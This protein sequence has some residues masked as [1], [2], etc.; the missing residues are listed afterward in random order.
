MYV[1][2]ISKEI[3]SLCHYHECMHCS[4][5][6]CVGFSIIRTIQLKYWM[7]FFFF[8]DIVV[9]L[10]LFLLFMFT[11]VVVVAVFDFQLLL[12]AACAISVP[13]LLMLLL[14]FYLLSFQFLNH[15]VPFTLSFSLSS[16]FL[17]LLF[18]FLL[19]AI[20]SLN[21]HYIQ[22]YVFCCFYFVVVVRHLWCVYFVYIENVLV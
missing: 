15:F 20:Y 16:K 6:V 13:A 4:V 8:A 14:L 12:F 19:L 7:N 17:L 10:L 1:C 5:W 18:C 3:S 11:I 21:T 9:F 2:V 22:I